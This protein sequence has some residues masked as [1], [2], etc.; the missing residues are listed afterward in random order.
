MTFYYEQ[1]GQGPDV[2][3]LHGWS[4]HGGVWVDVARALSARYRVTVFDLPGHGR[5]RDVVLPAFTPEALAESVQRVVSGPAI[6]I[7]WSL[8]GFIALA[9]AQHTPQTVTQLVLVG[10]TPKYVR[11]ADWPHAMLPSVLEQFAQNVEVDYAATF[12]RFLS[13]Q[14]AAGEDRDML[15]RLRDELFR[16]GEPTPAALRGGLQLLKDEDRRAVLA[17]IKAPT[18]VIHGERD[19]LVP[20]GAAHYMAGQIPDARLQVIPGA[21]HAPFLSHPAVFMQKL[22]EFLHA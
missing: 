19:R 17:G 7:G 22:N 12:T 20:V 10:A 13:L 18:L 9:A 4:F 15:R 8:G 3:L 6:W 14:T 11:S 1:H 21:G 2:V 5:S 16:Y